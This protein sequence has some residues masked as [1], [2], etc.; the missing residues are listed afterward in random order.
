MMKIT[1]LSHLFKWENLHNW[2]LTKYF[3]APLYYYIAEAHTSLISFVFFSSFAG[4]LFNILF[5]QQHV[6]N[7]HPYVHPF[8]I[9]I[10]SSKFLYVLA[11]AEA[12]IY[13]YSSNSAAV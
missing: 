4:G 6:L 9:C 10:G 7:I 5:V 2:C 8:A 1:G 13:N 3:F 11:V 12:I